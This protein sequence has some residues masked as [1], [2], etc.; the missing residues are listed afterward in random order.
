MLRKIFA[1]GAF[2]ASFVPKFSEILHK[3]GAKEAQKV[4]SEAF[5]FLFSAVC[6]VCIL[7]IVFYHYVLRLVAPSFQVGSLQYNIGMETGR[8]CFLFLMAASL[9]ALFS[10]ILNSYN[11]FVLSSSIQCIFNLSLM[12]AVLAGPLCFANVAYTMSCSVVIAGALQTAI[13]WLRVKN[14]AFG[15]GFKP[16]FF[17]SEVK[18]IAGNMIPAM[19][20]YGVWQI[21]ML[22][23]MRIASS[24]SV[25]TVTYLHFADRLN[26]LP[27]SLIGIATGTSLLVALSLSLAK[28]RLQFANSQFNASV[29]VVTSLSMPVLFIAFILAPELITIVFKRGLFNEYDVLITSQALMGFM[30][31][32]P[33]YVLSK[34]FTATFFALKDTI[35]P[36]KIGIVSV[37]SNI[38]VLY[39]L[40]PIWAHVGIALATSISSWVNAILLYCILYKRGTIKIYNSTWRRIFLQIAAVSIASIFVYVFASFIRNQQFEGARLAFFT[41]LNISIGCFLFIACGHRLGGFNAKAFLKKLK[42]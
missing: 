2:Q 13:L 32:L 42:K 6:L 16:R 5:S 22:V 36:V 38:I 41:F 17:S 27:L 11:K 7:V 4:A 14:V 37:V 40:S 39:V 8:L 18:G 26:Q 35:T 29:L 28:K 12:V 25:G 33:A 20:S 30:S 21:N 19:L 34:V 1:E 10:G 24:M 3:Q 31:G 23:D 9:S 15:V